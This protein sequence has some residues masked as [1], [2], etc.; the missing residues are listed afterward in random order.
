MIQGAEG[1]P[2]F[3]KSEGQGQSDGLPIL[4]KKKP[5]ETV[6]DVLVEFEKVLE[7]QEQ[8]PEL[9]DAFFAGIGGAISRGIHSLE[10]FGANWGHQ[11]ADQ[12]RAG[13][14]KMVREAFYSSRPLISLERVEEFFKE[15][16]FSSPDT[17]ASMLRE[18]DKSEIAQAE[19]A[20][21]IMKYIMDNHLDLISSS[22]EEVKKE[23]GR[24]IQSFIRG[25]VFRLNSYKEGSSDFAQV[26]DYIKTK[27]PGFDFETFIPI[28]KARFSHQILPQETIGRVVQRII[29]LENLRPGAAEALIKDFGIKNFG[30]YPAE[31][32][33][34]QLD[35]MDE[36]LPYG[37]FLS[38][39]SDWNNSLHMRADVLGDFY[40]QLKEKGEFLRIAEID[41]TVDVFRAL[42]D[43]DTKYGARGKI[44]FGILNA[45]GN[46]NVI[47]LGGADK[48]KNSRINTL[49]QEEMG[50][51]EEQAFMAIKD[52]FVPN[53]TIIL[54]SCNTGVEEGIGQ[55]ISQK[56]QARVIG[57]VEPAYTGSVEVT[58]ADTLEFKVSYVG[59]NGVVKANEFLNGEKVNWLTAP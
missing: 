3:D 19:D 32:L 37:V 44:D 29:E 4:E 41:G 48:D 7:Y 49:R 24:L 39:E 16:D 43:F 40:S 11:V 1:L 55:A 21:R 58:G 42:R 45:H 59:E 38:A 9:A 53:P 8:A 23:F 14:I 36:D 25:H 56:L 22:S 34:D 51:R 47:R 57:P 10:D 46:K 15:G 17:T 5:D 2:V 35:K 30:R 28:W 33:L 13:S 52:F 12:P 6:A 54:E 26:M 20:Y 31:L 50:Q 27:A 18:L